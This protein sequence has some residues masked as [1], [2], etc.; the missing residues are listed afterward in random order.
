MP[1]LIL[2]YH[3]LADDVRSTPREHRPYVISPLAFRRQLELI[4]S[5]AIPVV[6][7]SG[8]CT[9]PR[10]SR[11]IVI[12]FDDGHTSNYHL[13][14]PIL[15]EPGLKATFFVTAGSIGKH[16]TLGWSDIRDL[17]ASGMEI[18]SHTVTHRPPSTLNDT[19]LRYELAESR[20]ILEDGLGAPVTSISSPTGFFNP[21]MRRIAQ[22]LGYRG[23]CFGRIGLA[24][25][26]GDPFSLNRIAAKRSLGETRFR[27]LVRFD[28]ATI[29]CLRLEQSTR[30]LAREILGPAGYLRLRSLLL[31]G[32]EQIH[33]RTSA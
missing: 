11:A 21:R 29:A 9:Q 6:T 8:W 15:L 28:R 17:Y 19:E 20:R 18:G 13:A 12:T 30:D 22:E 5:A 7:V 10:P 23:L 2:M 27:A 26:N 16:G 25:D 1:A 3:D 31:R 4:K 33:S 24:A 14:L 32:S